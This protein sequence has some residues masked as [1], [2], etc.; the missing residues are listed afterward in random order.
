MSKKVWLLCGGGSFL[1]AC[2][3][4]VWVTLPVVITTQSV[5]SGYF[6]NNKANLVVALRRRSIGLLDSLGVVTLVQGVAA[7]V[8]NDS[9]NKNTNRMVRF[10]PSI[11]VEASGSV[12]WNQ[13]LLSLRS[14][15]RGI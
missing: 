14:Y 3:L 7:Y 1:V 10:D 8:Q 13:K 4:L 9:H 15:L 6:T 5:G 11:D 2:S 12:C